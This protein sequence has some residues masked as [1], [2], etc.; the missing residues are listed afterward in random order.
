MY[1]IDYTWLEFVRSSQKRDLQVGAQSGH[2]DFKI[3]RFFTSAC[4]QQREWRIEKLDPQRRNYGNSWRLAIRT[5]AGFQRDRYEVAYA[6]AN[7]RRT[8]PQTRHGI[9][10]AQHYNEHMYW[11]GFAQ[12]IDE[13]R[14]G[15]SLVR[16]GHTAGGPA[17]KTIFDNRSGRAKMWGQRARSSF[18]LAV[19][20]DLAKSVFQIH[21]VDENGLVLVRRQLRRSQLLAFFQKRP[22]C[23]NERESSPGFARVA[24]AV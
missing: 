15:R 2:L 17:A 14:L 20:I 8:L 22:R 7:R 11:P 24:I 5:A 12:N 1:A 19:G 16:R 21:G 10:R 9:I 13:L 23:L 6:L 18:A 4:K 3:D